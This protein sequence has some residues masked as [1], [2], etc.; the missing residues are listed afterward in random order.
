M[1]MDITPVTKGEKV[2]FHNPVI[3]FFNAVGG[4]DGMRKLMYSF[5]DKIYESDIAYFFPQDEEEFEKIK[6]KN[7]KFFIQICGGPKVYEDEAQG[8]D[9]NEFMIRVHDDFS[10]TEKAR[11]EWLGTIRE[12]L[13]ELEGV[14][15]QLI[16]DFWG[17]LESFSKLTVNT[18]ADGSIFYA[19]YTQSAEEKLN[20]S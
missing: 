5:Y 3:E 8:M 4:E 1:P 12:A 10:I 13:M 18:F 17:Y 14:D 15:T 9:L 2:H 7:T 6:V 20:N 19:A 16:E 11:I